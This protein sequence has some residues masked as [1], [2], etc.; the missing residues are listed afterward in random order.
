VVVVAGL[1][2]SWM[3]NEPAPVIHVSQRTQA[4]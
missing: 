2:F 4:G 3:W 1:L